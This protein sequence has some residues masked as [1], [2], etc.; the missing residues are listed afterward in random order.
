VLHA[1]RFPIGE[2][3]ALRR[4]DYAPTP[5]SPNEEFPFL[6]VTGRSLY[7]FNAGTMTRRT[8]N[9]LIRP[10]DVLDV[11]PDDAGR[12][13]LEEGARVRIHSRHGEAML[14]V[15]VNPAV[16][17]GEAFATFHTA[18]IFLNRVTGPHRDGYTGTP[19]YKVTAIQVTRA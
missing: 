4:L 14:P 12:L 6:L 13:G 9:S 7:Q 17:A 8:K 19:E 10:S 11:S 3:A 1:E 16:K 2:R 18:E 15:H 5:E